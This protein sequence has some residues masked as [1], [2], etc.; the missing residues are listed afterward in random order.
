MADRIPNL[1]WDDRSQ[2]KLWVHRLTI[3][4]ALAVARGSPIIIQ[5]DARDEERPDGTIGVRPPRLLL[6]GPDRSNRMVTLVIEYPR[7]DFSSRIVTG[8]RAARKEHAWYRQRKNR[9]R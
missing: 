4:D 7:D 9:E 6:I 8:W 5:Q 2:D 3:D 1:R